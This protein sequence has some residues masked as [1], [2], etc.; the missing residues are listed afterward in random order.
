MEEHTV[1][2]P[3]AAEAAWKDALY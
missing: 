3:G 1:E 2:M